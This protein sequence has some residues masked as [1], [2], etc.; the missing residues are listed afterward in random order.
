MVTTVNLVMVHTYFEIGRAIVEDEQH[1]NA[2]ATYGKSVLK[3]ISQE[4]TGQ[5]GKGFSVDNLENMRQFYLVYSIS[6]TVSRKFVLSWSHYLILMRIDN[7][8][9][10]SFYEIESA[11]G[12]WS[13]RELQRQIDSALYERLALSRDKQRVKEL[14]KLYLPDKQ[15]LQQK[16]LEWTAHFDNE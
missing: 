15:L 1:G 11:A 7:P 5:F 2:R 8:D 9:Q 10:R 16:L 3:E 12:S 14:N 6:E 13:L 4:L